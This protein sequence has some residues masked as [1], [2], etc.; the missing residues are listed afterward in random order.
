MPALS[1]EPLTRTT[2]NLF[3]SDVVW[4]KAH[5]GPGFTQEI[6]NVIRDFV[7]QH[8]RTVVKVTENYLEEDFDE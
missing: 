1:H 5:Y 3:L 2:L 8:R 4:F 6:R 7:R